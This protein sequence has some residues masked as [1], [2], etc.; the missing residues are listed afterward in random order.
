M[1][2][3]EV[4][5]YIIYISDEGARLLDEVFKKELKRILKDE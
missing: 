2:K 1:N 4:D 5:D 3:I